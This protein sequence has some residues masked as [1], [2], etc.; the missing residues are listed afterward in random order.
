MINGYIYV[1]A[2]VIDE[3]GPKMLLGID[4]IKEYRVWIDIYINKCTFRLIFGIKVK[5]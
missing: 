2:N 1:R 4:F 3:L 5:G